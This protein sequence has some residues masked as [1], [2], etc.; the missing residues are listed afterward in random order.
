MQRV[1]GVITGDIKPVLDLIPYTVCRQG[2]EVESP[3]LEGTGRFAGKTGG[4]SLEV[5]A[6]GGGSAP[7]C[8]TDKTQERSETLLAFPIPS[9]TGFNDSYLHVSQN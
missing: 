6:P 4:A 2:S 5:F 9:K 3:A 1:F 7:N 8:H